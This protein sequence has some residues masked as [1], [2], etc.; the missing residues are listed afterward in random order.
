[1]VSFLLDTNV[2]SE[3]RKGPRAD[4]KVLRWLAEVPDDEL[5]T[6]VLVV[7]EVRRGVESIRRR[8][9]NSAAALDASLEQLKANFADRILAVDLRVAEQWARLTCPIRCR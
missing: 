9:P 2:L 7:G 1:V 5:F 8:D 6:S 4:P 3:L